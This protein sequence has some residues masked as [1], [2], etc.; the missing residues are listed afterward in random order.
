[1]RLVE[2]D[3]ETFRRQMGISLN[4]EGIPAC[5]SLAYLVRQALAR[6]RLA[7]REQIRAYVKQQLEAVNALNEQSQER[8]KEVLKRLLELRDMEEVTVDGRTQLACTLTRWVRLGKTTA[9][10]TGTL[11]HSPVPLLELPDETSDSLAALVRY[12][13]P[14][15]QETGLALQAAGVAEWSLE[16]WRGRPA[17]LEHMKR[18]TNETVQTSTGL[19]DFWHLLV[20]RLKKPVRPLMNTLKYG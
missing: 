7:S 17:Y 20:R 13:N 18:R 3:R 9:A 4:E 5:S 19:A 16:S 12:F 15:E 8:L 2:I 11:A 1:M 6:W 14:E 10:L